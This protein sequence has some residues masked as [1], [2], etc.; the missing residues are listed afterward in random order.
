MKPIALLCLISLLGCASTDGTEPLPISA[1]CISFAP[2][3]WSSRD[4]EE[5]QREIF[6]HNLAWEALCEPQPPVE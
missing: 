1:A 3:G 5:T 4:T 2:L 6:K